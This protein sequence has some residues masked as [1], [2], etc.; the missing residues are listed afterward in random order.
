MI[1]KKLAV[2]FAIAAIAGAAHAAAPMAKTQAPG[3]YR[4]NVGDFEVSVLNDGTIDLPMDQ[5]LHQKPEKTTKTLEHSFLK[6]PVETS[7]NAFLVNT[8]T[9]LVLIDTGAGGLFG[10]TLGNI[11]S[12][13][14]AAGYQPEQVDEI[15]ITHLHGD[16]V[17]GLGAQDKPAF[18]NAVV[19]MDK[20]DADYF[21]SKANLDKASAE[22]KDNFQ[23][24]IKAVSGY[25]GKV[26][27]FEGNTELVPGVR[28]SSSYGHTPGHTT[29]VVESKG[30]KLVLIGDLMH[31]AAVQLP[32]PGV[33]IQF[34]SDSKAALAQRKAAFAEAAKQGYWMGAAHLPFPGVGHLRAEGKGYKFFPVNYSANR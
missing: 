34:D 18:P 13:L 23:G 15:Y 12:S 24:P 17:G 30:Q 28:S 19:R 10:P 3:F 27:P 9:K 25:A 22:A 7:V 11:L 1:L 26:K 16:H 32:D 5:L 20:R 21:L 6:S 33:T 2:P 31:N 14:K 8:G 29:Y 4:M